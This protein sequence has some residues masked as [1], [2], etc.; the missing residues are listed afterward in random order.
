MIKSII[1]DRNEILYIHID[2]YMDCCLV[3]LFARRWTVHCVHHCLNHYFF[4]TQCVVVEWA[5]LLKDVIPYSCQTDFDAGLWQT[6]DNSVHHVLSFCN[7]KTIL[8]QSLMWITYISKKRTLVNA[9][10]PF[11]GFLHQLS[12]GTRK[13]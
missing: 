11:C 3:V 13:V 7:L 4:A 9:A 10:S 2:I 8:Q 1:D 5:F 6:T 12:R